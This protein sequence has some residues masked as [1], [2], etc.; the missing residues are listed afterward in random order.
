MAFRMF[1]EQDC[2]V[3]KLDGKKVAIVGVCTPETLTKSTPTYFQNEDGEFRVT[4]T[5]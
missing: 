3:S 5:R 1:H 4:R 2:D